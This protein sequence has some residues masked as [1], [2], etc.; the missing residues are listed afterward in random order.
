[1]RALVGKQQVALEAWN[2]IVTADAIW[3]F[4][5]GVG[6]DNP[7]WS[8]QRY[9]ARSPYGEIIAPPAYLYSHTSGPRDP[10]KTGFTAIETCLPGV[11][12]LWASE[13]WLWHRPVFVGEGISGATG[14]DSVVVNPPGKFGGRSVTQVDKCVFATDAGEVIAESYMTIKRFEREQVRSNQRYLNRPLAKY[15]QEDRDRFARQYESEATQ[16]RG[17]DPRYV[18][19]ARIGDSVGPILKGPL[20]VANMMGY[21]MGQGAPMT[22][23]NRIHNHY[24]NLFPQT[25]MVH[26]ES[27]VAEN[28]ETPHWDAAFARLSGLPAGYD[29][30]SQRFSWFA[31]LVTDWA[32]DHG[33]LADLEM[34]LIMPNLIGDVHWLAG[35]V[36]GLEANIATLSLTSTNQLGDTTAVAQAKVRLPNKGDLT[37]HLH[38]RKQLKV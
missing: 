31:H 32:G 27:G 24:L 20:T 11:L 17:S 26:P 29:F 8:D 23:T 22:T 12:G 15:T 18:E 3:H 14:L 35:S 36:S 6:D 16:R 34:K 9:G 19:D 25:L 7:L 5:L 30:G 13:R 33:M 1:M 37:S 21:L 4:A 38:V 28:Y 2:H 10:E